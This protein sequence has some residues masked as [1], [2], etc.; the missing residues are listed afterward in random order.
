MPVVGD[1]WCNQLEEEIVSMTGSAMFGLP[2]AEALRNGPPEIRK[3]RTLGIGWLIYGFTR[4]ARPKTVVEIG[5]GGSSACILWGLKHNEKGH[6]HTCDVFASGDND[7]VHA[8]NIG[9]QIV[10]EKN[11]DGSPMNHNKATVIRM[12]RKW[13]MEN[14]VTIYHES[15]KDFVPRWD[16]PIDMVVVD[17]N[18]S[19][20]FLENDI[21]LLNH[22][23][24]G[25]YAL[26]H[27]FTACISEVGVT[28]LDFVNSSDEWSLIVEPNCLS[29][30]VLQRKW[31]LSPKE[32]FTANYLA[33]ANNPN[34]MNTPFQ[35]TDPRAV[36]AVKKWNGRCFPELTHFHDEQPAGEAIAKRIIEFEKL[37]G[38]TVEDL[39]EVWEG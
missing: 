25:G 15:S 32:C 26:F 38:R 34:G 37:T 33:T 13:G 35:M 23:V 36:G 19:K 17:G 5:T 1:V 3:P 24:P 10:Y 4:A 8:V 16:G 18:H 9:G 11:D 22:L 27:D 39:S 6:L 28:I 12:I 30:A 31:S 29:M 2:G 14:I 21:Q 20:D 7:D